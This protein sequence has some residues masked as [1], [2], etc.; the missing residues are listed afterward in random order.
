[1][2]FCG[3]MG[4]PFMDYLIADATVIPPELRVYYDEKIISMPHSFFVNDHKQSARCV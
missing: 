3:T 4:A 2:G 1:M